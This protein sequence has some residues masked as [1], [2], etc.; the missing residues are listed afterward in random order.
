MREEV[1]MENVKTV[2]A[3]F[4]EGIKGCCRKEGEASYE[5]FINENLSKE[6]QKEVYEHELYHIKNGDFDMFDVQEI[7]LNAHKNLEDWKLE[8][9]EQAKNS[10]RHTRLALLLSVAVNI[11]LV[12]VVIFK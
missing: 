9:V 8:L 4:P 2:L 3:D 12:L 5:I 1:K 11:A 6:E 7:E 10:L